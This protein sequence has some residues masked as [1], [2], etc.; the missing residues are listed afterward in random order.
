MI[1]AQIF[2]F[3]KLQIGLLTSSTVTYRQSNLVS[4][5]LNQY[6]H[7]LFCYYKLSN[8][9]VAVDLM[10]EVMILLDIK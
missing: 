10:M 5:S 2:Q 8:T 3:S 4:T 6:I 9:S 7:S 1:D